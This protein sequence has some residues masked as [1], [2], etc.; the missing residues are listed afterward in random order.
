[1]K[2]SGIPS[3]IELCYLDAHRYPKECIRAIRERTQL[4]IGQPKFPPCIIYGTKQSPTSTSHNFS[5]A[6]G[7]YNSSTSGDYKYHVV[8]FNAR[9]IISTCE[10]FYDCFHAWAKYTIDALD[11]MLAPRA[12]CKELLSKILATEAV[13]QGDI[14]MDDEL[15]KTIT[16]PIV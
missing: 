9:T 3:W 15:A 16:I 11:G 1:M 12:S 4:E 13:I 14:N 8:D 7:D 5:K 2:H 10:T 6:S